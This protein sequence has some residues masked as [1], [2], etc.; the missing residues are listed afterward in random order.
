MNS[1]KRWMSIFNKANYKYGLDVLTALDPATGPRNPID[2]V[3][4]ALYLDAD[5]DSAISL[6]RNKPDARRIHVVT[7][8]IW[9]AIS[10]L[11]IG[12][13]LNG[14]SWAT[15][16]QARHRGINHTLAEEEVCIPGSKTAL[17]N[18]P[19]R[20][21][22]GGIR[23]LSTNPAKD[24]RHRVTHLE[25]PHGEMAVC[26]ELPYSERDGADSDETLKLDWPINRHPSKCRP[27]CN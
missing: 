20:P 19:R 14:P 22:V 27:R 13:G 10:K 23:S 8:V 9:R 2:W 3:S 7:L 25:T 18:C 17:P 21:N 5:G 1:R 11:G 12:S 24:S 15:A 4:I 6:V 26:T 16:H